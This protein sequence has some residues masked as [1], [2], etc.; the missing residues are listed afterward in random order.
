MSIMQLKYT[1]SNNDTPQNFILMLLMAG[2][3]GLSFGV[4]LQISCKW[5]PERPGVCKVAQHSTDGCHKSWARVG[6]KARTL[7][8]SP[9]LLIQIYWSKSTDPNVPIQIYQST[10]N[11]PNLLIQMY[12]SKSTVPHLPIPIYTVS[13]LLITI[14][15]SKSTD[16][17]LL[18]QS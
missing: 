14:Y 7:I 13:N 15:S 16:P 2:S 1:Q 4:S 3:H 5:C 12:W 18:I 8:Y 10:S 9:H 6:H 11:D 17:N